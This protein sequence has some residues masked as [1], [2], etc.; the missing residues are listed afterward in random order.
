MGLSY[1]GGFFF[2]HA[3]SASGGS[4]AVPG[5]I[6]AMSTKPTITPYRERSASILWRVSPEDREEVKKRAADAGMSVA[7]YIAWRAL[8]QLPPRLAVTEDSL[9]IAM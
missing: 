6:T 3:R 4:V 7:E 8:D 5:W 1:M 9:P 2:R